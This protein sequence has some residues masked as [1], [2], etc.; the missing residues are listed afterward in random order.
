MVD[1]AVHWRN[2]FF[3]LINLQFLMPVVVKEGFCCRQNSVLST[4]L[5]P[6]KFI[7]ISAHIVSRHGPRLTEIFT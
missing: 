6:W 4:S 7:D 1:A 5:Y 2:I 3:G